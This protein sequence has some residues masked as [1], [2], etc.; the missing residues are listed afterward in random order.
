MSPLVQVVTKV[1]LQVGPFYVFYLQILRHYRTSL[2]LLYYA[3]D[4]F[5]C[6]EGNDVGSGPPRNRVGQISHS[7]VLGTFNVG[8][9]GEGIV[10]DLTRVCYRI[11]CVYLM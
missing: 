3:S 11:L 9:Q 8:E 6:L 4:I 2:V 7:V 1:Y 5:R 10:H